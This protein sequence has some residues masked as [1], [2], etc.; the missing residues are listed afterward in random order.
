MLNRVINRVR[1]LFI[2]ICV[3]I[4]LY[5]STGLVASVMADN[6]QFHK[7]EYQNHLKQQ[8]PVFESTSMWESIMYTG[9]DVNSSSVLLTQNY[10][11]YQNADNKHAVIFHKKE[12]RLFVRLGDINVRAYFIIGMNLNS[13][14]EWWSVYR[15]RKDDDGNLYTQMYNE[16]IDELRV[17]AD[18]CARKGEYI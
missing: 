11:H 15:I 2:V 13:P 7:K 10:I 5:F 8:R 16:M 17:I 3:I 12:T 4:A 9:V 1:M 14:T 18:R 6:S